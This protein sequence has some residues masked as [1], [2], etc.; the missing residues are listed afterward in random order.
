M[1]F[2]SF[3]LF[4]FLVV[5]S[6]FATDY[7]CDP[8]NGNMNNNG[9]QNAPWSTLED[10][11]NTG[12][13]FQ[14]DDVIYLLD[15]YHGNVSVKGVNA[16]FVII[17]N[18]PGA[19]PKLS[20]LQFGVPVATSKWII[21]GLIVGAEFNGA[22]HTNTL[23]YTGNIAS[24]IKIKD[25]IVFSKEDI[26]SWTLSDWNNKVSNGVIFDGANCSIENT[27]V[28]NVR[29]GLQ[30]GAMNCSASYNTV[31]NFAGDGMRGLADNGTFKYNVVKDNYAID[32][33][34]DDGFQSWTNEGG[35]GKGTLKN[36]VLIGNIFINYTDPDR[37]FLGPMQGIF[38]TDG[39]FEGFVLENNV[40]IVDH[41]HGISLYGA[42]NCRIINNTVIDAYF[43]V[44]YPNHPDPNV[45]GPLGPSWIKI[46]NHKN[47]TQSTGNIVRNN[48][49]NQIVLGNTGV[50]VQDHN[51]I[52]IGNNS[53]DYEVEF[54]DWQNFDFH[55]KENA[56]AIDKASENLAP[57]LDA[58]RN[59]RPVGTAFDIGAYEYSG[60]LSVNDESIRSDLRIYPTFNREGTFYLQ[61]YKVL[62]K[63][64][65]ISLFDLQGSKI[66]ELRIFP[67]SNSTSFHFDYFDHLNTGIYFILIQSNRGKSITK[68]FKSN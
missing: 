31:K 12:K 45:R 44:T 6:I 33:N 60:S 57:V 48:I 15:G 32:T 21:E 58:D 18:F 65:N 61:T 63:E 55:L 66:E 38:G 35:V 37:D 19:N 3:I 43:G 26:S 23:I 62:N 28:K 16:D 1:K 64:L 68:V 46:A 51:L 17:K 41:W 5:N 8:E 4:S 13:V 27:M 20:R 53:G 10:V 14:S 56:T 30:F 34:H 40:V 29:T 50:G 9:S 42:T 36:I 59:S 47:G 24:F 39:M 22:Y 25:C 52:L 54:I 67:N 7:Y 49:A 2:I 11:F